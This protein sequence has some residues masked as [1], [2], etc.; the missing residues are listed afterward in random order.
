MI[1]VAYRTSPLAGYAENG[2]AVVTRIDAASNRALFA[3]I[4]GLGHGPRASEAAIRASESLEIAP[5]DGEVGSLM[6]RLHL[7]LRG[8]RGAAA[9]VCMVDAHELWVCGVGNVALRT[10]GT[11]VPFVLSPGILG[12]RVQRFRSAN[13]R[14]KAGDRVVLHSDGIRPAF[15]LDRLRHLD[16]EAASNELFETCRRPSDDASVLVA[17]FG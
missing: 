17:D 1:Q 14:M 12:A 15:A 5:L 10:L 2:D 4:D 7:A 11:Q 13:A 16:A 6:E 9:T 3:V 8:T